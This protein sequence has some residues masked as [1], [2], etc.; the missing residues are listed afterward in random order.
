[1]ATQPSYFGKT[2]VG[3]HPHRRQKNTLSHLFGRQTNRKKHPSCR[4]P[5]LCVD[6]LRKYTLQVRCPICRHI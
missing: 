3:R 4:V 1:M 5:I 6:K 2:K